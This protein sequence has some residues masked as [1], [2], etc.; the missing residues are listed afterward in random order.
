MLNVLEINSLSLNS[1]C[2]QVVYSQSKSFAQP[3]LVI[4]SIIK[5]INI[6]PSMWVKAP[7]FPQLIHSILP[8]FFNA[9]IAVYRSVIQ[10]NHIAYNYIL[11][12]NNILITK[13]G[14]SA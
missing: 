4:R 13:Q 7:A 8:K 14:T 3:G 5:R 11:L 9:F 6:L 12:I 2:G 1:C 10:L